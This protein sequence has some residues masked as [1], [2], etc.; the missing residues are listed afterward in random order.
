ML[1]HLMT[2]PSLYNLAYKFRKPYLKSDNQRNCNAKLMVIYAQN[3]NLTKSNT[4]D[5][6]YL[7]HTETGHVKTSVR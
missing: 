5:C 4:V 2:L 7:F 1:Q 3:A 6:V